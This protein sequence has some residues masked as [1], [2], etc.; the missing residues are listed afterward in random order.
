MIV[1]NRALTI[2]VDNQIIFWQSKPQHGMLSGYQNHCESRQKSHL[3]DRQCVWARAEPFV[4][5]GNGRRDGRSELEPGVGPKRPTCQ[6]Q[7]RPYGFHVCF[8]H[9]VFGL[10]WL[11]FQ[12]FFPKT[13]RELQN[14]MDRVHVLYG[15]RL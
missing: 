4:L 2:V 6:I 10:I 3:Q 5:H 11:E 1:S 14:P 9:P 12:V 8:H 7:L 13:G 15:Y